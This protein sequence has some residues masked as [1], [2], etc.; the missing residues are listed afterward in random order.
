MKL[1]DIYYEV[2]PYV[3]RTLQV[4]FRQQ[5]AAAR[6]RVKQDKWPIDRRAA[7]APPLWEGW[8]GGK[9]FALVLTHDV[10]SAAGHAQCLELAAL[11][12]ARGLRSSFNFVIEGYHVSEA[13]RRCLVE[14]G[15]EIGVHGVYHDGKEFK[16]RKIFEKRAPII[17]RCLK[18]WQSVG[19]RAPAMY[20]RHDWLEELRIEYDSSTFDTDPFEVEATA[21]RTIFP[22]YVNGSTDGRGYVELP[23]TLA[24][25]FTLFV[26][27]KNRDIDTWKQKLD[28]IAGHGGMALII[29][30]PD[31]M[32]FGG[33]KA[34]FGRYP[35]D[36]YAQFLD[37]V[38]SRYQ[39]QFWNVLPRDV[40]WFWKERQKAVGPPFELK[41]RNNIRVCMP[42]YS[43]YDTDNRIIRYAETLVKR[44]DQVDV[45]ALK[46]P[47]KP[48][49]DVLNGVRV[50]RI[51]ERIPNEKGKLDYLGRLLKFF[52]RSAKLITK[53]H[54]RDPYD[55]I[56]VHSVPDFEVFVALVPK[57]TGC[58][59]MLD[60]H[61]IV[62][63]FYASK[64]GAS[65]K[66][67]L[68][69]ILV[70]IEKLSARF[71]DHV[72]VSNHLWEQKLVARSVPAS[73]CTVILN[74]PDQETFHKREKSRTDEKLIILYPG[75]LNYH[76]GLD[77]AIRAFSKISGKL[78][79]A[80]LHIYGEGAEKGN[81]KNLAAALSV[82]G[83]VKFF[84]LLSINEISSVMADCDLGIVPKRNDSFGGEAFSTKILEF[85]SLGVPVLVSSTRIDRLY[86]NDEVVQFF[87][88]EDEDD[89]AEKLVF[90][91]KDESFRKILSASALTMARNFSWDL[92][93]VKYLEVVDS[94]SASD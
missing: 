86:F 23:Y 78:P 57:L 22:F 28:W 29:T 50:F 16:S 1:R 39:G 31:Y 64:F 24:Q 13:L 43:F 61:D 71:S 92:K 2:R 89:L 75:S 17:N 62:P 40:A 30:H 83:R 11:E 10:E 70:T 55:L 38:N 82:D 51:Q 8:P 14:N 67:M 7:G 36:Y 37:Y 53:L 94:L 19:F 65:P 42:A 63:E 52:F 66:G 12:M 41:H 9:K 21:V 73:K 47:G 79:E 35:A 72:I 26:L 81:L 4:M 87:N 20:C 45:I 56:H 59:I 80:E 6:H 91:L 33:S 69:N 25:D 77:I 74:Y 93:K 44:G 3:P 15:Y 46:E 34:G 76:Q 90:L 18:E 88:A 48:D 32:N 27:L 84:N 49:W 60:I 54:L 5:I 68:F 58:K 85:M